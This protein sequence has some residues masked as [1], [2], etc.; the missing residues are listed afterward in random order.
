M[1]ARESRT[2]DLPLRTR[3]RGD[4]VLQKVKRLALLSAA[5]LVH[6]HAEF[7]VLRLDLLNREEFGPRGQNGGLDH[8]VLGP[9]EAEEVTQPAGVDDLRLDAHPLSALVHRRDAELIVTAGGR[10]DLTA[11]AR[12]GE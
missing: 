9:V 2:P 5:G 12:S 1:R 3:D 11:G 4:V 8:G 6:E 10:G 7:A